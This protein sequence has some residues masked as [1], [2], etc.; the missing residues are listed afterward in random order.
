MVLPM[1]FLAPA[2][3]EVESQF[4]VVS[5]QINF[6]YL[7]CLYLQCRHDNIYLNNEGPVLNPNMTRLYIRMV[8]L[9]VLS[10]IL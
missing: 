9:R 4:T 10:A 1:H 8:S 2:L 3:S 7:H 6:T 5:L